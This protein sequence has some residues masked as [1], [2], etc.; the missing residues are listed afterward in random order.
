[1]WY[2]NSWASSHIT[3]VGHNIQKPCGFSGNTCLLTADGSPLQITSSGHSSVPISN[4]SIEFN[5][6]LHVPTA[7]RNLLS[8]NKLCVDNNLCFVFDSHTVEA[9]DRA[10]GEVAL[11]GVAKGGLYEMK[12]PIQRNEAALLCDSQSRWHHHLGHLNHSYLD[13]L[14][15]KVSINCSST[16]FSICDSC[17]MAKSHALPHPPCKMP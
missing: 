11:R 13:I 1:M 17:Q 9:R 8:V 15:K 14:I 7:T 2:P 10:T 5:D 12:I 4:K 6:I 16:P 3:A